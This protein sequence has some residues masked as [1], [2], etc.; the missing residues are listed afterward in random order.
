MQ[1]CRPV[2]WVLCYHLVKTW[3]ASSPLCDC[4][5]NSEKHF[6]FICCFSKVREK[7]QSCVT[8]LVIGLYKTHVGHNFTCF[9]SLTLSCSFSLTHSHTPLEM[10]V[11]ICRVIIAF[12]N[13]LHTDFTKY[14]HKNLQMN[15]WQFLL[16][17]YW[18]KKSS[19]MFLA[20]IIASIF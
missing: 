4:H 9:L 3:K 18:G 6:S 2:S 7:G 13:S 1:M 12:Y 19:L 8:H 17:P 20:F 11:A 16:E 15:S 14:W 10:T 5:K